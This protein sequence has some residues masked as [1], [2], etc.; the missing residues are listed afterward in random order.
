MEIHGW[1]ILTEKTEEL[2][3]KPVTTATLSTT[4][5]TLT[6]TSANPGL[7]GE[8]AATKSLSKNFYSRQPMNVLQIQRCQSLHRKFSTARI[9]QMS[10]DVSDIQPYVLHVKW[11][12]N[13][14][15][16]DWH[17]GVGDRGLVITSLNTLC[18]VLRNRPAVDNVKPVTENCS[19]K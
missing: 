8:R 19:A 1:K 15:E 5:F 4:N 6:D 2:L 17:L 9:S 10:W 12:W 3:Q 14:V 7:L 16:M 11:G 18:S 13:T